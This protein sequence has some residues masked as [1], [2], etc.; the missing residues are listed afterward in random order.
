MEPK[1]TN[2]YVSIARVP[3]TI[4]ILVVQNTR[5][6]RSQVGK[7]TFKVTAVGLLRQTDTQYYETSNDDHKSYADVVNLDGCHCVLRRFSSLCRLR[8]GTKWSR[9]LIVSRFWICRLRVVKAPVACSAWTGSALTC[10]ELRGSGL[11]FS[12]RVDGVMMALQLKPR[13]NV[14]NTKRPSQ[15]KREIS[16]GWQTEFIFRN[17]VN[18][19]VLLVLL[20]T[21]TGRGKSCKNARINLQIVSQSYGLQF[22]AFLINVFAVRGCIG[23]SSLH[24][25]ATEGLDNCRIVRVQTVWWFDLKLGTS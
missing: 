3:P 8:C 5:R 11:G 14:D 4:L 1:H 15:E 21:V 22:R 6:Q 23:P 25:G 16:W 12:T 9:R 18:V 7:V 19:V 17:P 13:S 2:T 10:S 24:Y 20:L